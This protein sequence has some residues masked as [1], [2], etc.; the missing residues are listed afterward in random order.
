M[1]FPIRLANLQVLCDLGDVER[2]DRNRERER[3]RIAEIDERMDLRQR[4]LFPEAP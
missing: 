1:S 2:C 4:V 3:H